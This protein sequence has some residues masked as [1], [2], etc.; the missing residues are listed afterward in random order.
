MADPVDFSV[1]PVVAY[2][3]VVY[4]FFP[5]PVALV[6]FQVALALASPSKAVSVLFPSV[7]PVYFSGRQA[8]VAPSVGPSE[9][10]FPSLPLVVNPVYSTVSQ[11]V[12]PPSVAA[13]LS[14]L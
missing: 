10:V 8:I 9:V 6:Y 2:P 11:A 7:I 14:S 1:S 5:V 12:V 4:P 13:H 3:R